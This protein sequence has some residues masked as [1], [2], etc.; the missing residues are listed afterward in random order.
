MSMQSKRRMVVIAG[1]FVALTVGL[2]QIVAEDVVHAVSGVVTKVDSA[3]KTMAVKTA[4]GTE[5]VVKYTDKTIFHHA[6]AATEDAGKDA[7]KATVDTYM[8]G[9][10][11]GHAIVRYTEKGA[12]KV[13]VGVEDL[14]KDSVKVADGTVDHVDKAAHTVTVKTA[15]GAKDTYEVSKDAVVDTG[16]GVEKAGKWTYKEGD[17]VTV[18]YSEEAGK[19]IAHFIHKL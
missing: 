6:K 18:H 16:H 10:E 7:K 4:D 9:L 15:D 14:G 3:A 2:G 8:A 5:H 19:K 11:G 1:L 13:A 12:D 17:K